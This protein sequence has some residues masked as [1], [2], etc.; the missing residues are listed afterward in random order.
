MTLYRSVPKEIKKSTYLKLAEMMTY[1]ED[2]GFLQWKV[3]HGGKHE[4]K[5]AGYISDKKYGYRKVESKG[6]RY[7]CHIIAWIIST[8]KYPLTHLDHINGNPDDNSLSNL[9]DVP[10][11]L[12]QRNAPRKKTKAHIPY[13]GVR[14]VHN[15]WSVDCCGVKLGSFDCLGQAIL[16][17]KTE[18]VRLGGF[19]QRHSLR[20]TLV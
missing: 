1:D 13:V 4:G 16:A 6:T 8:G 17:R 3:G 15:K 7:F 12:N 2:T 9:R 20:P 10:A 18:E 5:R 14:R 19:T 11:N